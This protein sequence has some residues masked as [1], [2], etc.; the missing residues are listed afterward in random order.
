MREPDSQPSTDIDDDRTPAPSFN[1]DGQGRAG[2]LIQYVRL[3]SIDEACMVGSA[4]TGYRVTRCILAPDYK[5]SHLVKLNSVRPDALTSFRRRDVLDAVPGARL[6]AQAARTG[7]DV[8]G[9]TCRCIGKGITRGK[10]GKGK[11]DQYPTPVARAPVQL[12]VRAGG[13]AD[14]ARLHRN[15]RGAAP[16]VSTRRAKTVNTMPAAP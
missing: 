10:R 8:I 4:V 11:E 12:K 6:S 5:R 1:V 2:R 14:D 13:A 3:R 7:L 16:P 15:G 9:E